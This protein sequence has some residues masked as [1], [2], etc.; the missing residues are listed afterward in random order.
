MKGGLMSEI[1]IT[2]S[3]EGSGSTMPFDGKTCLWWVD[4]PAS[5][6]PDRD[7]DAWVGWVTNDPNT[8]LNDIIPEGGK[9][10]IW[11]GYQTQ[12]PPDLGW[13]KKTQVYCQ[14][15]PDNQDYYGSCVFYE[16]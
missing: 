13:Q 2:T 6:P 7:P 5:E 16:L 9:W 14:N 4:E 1:H 10:A 8:V 11:R 3:A 12:V 15:I